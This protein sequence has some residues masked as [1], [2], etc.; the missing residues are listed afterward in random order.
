M[1]DPWISLPPKSDP[2]ADP[3]M[4]P[5]GAKRPLSPSGSSRPANTGEASIT[6]VSSRQPL[7]QYWSFRF[8]G[9]K[10]SKFEDLLE[11]FTQDWIVEYGFQLERGEKN[12]V[13][14]Y[15]GAFEVEPRKRFCQLDEYFRGLFPELIF[16]GK[17]YLQRSRSCAADRYAMKEETRVGGPWYFGRRFDEIAKETVYKI[18]IELRQ[19][20]MNI[21]ELIRGPNSDRYIYWFWEPFGGLGKTTF[22]K[23]LF[24][25][26]DRVVVLSGKASDMKNGIVEY[27]EKQKAYPKIVL[28]NIP[29]TFNAD[30][31]SAPGTEEIKD[32]FF[33]SPKFHGGMVWGPPPIVLIFANCVPPCFT[34]M[35]KDRWRIYRLPDGQ[36][37]DVAEVFEEDWSAEI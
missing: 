35:A 36:A 30:Y 8:T 26:F 19:W 5:R 23:W 20:Q 31:F 25:E 29:K 33:Y 7:V 10:I 11:A 28:I 37:K 14:H 9:S 16:D 4:S 6:G 13:L 24:Q 32:M 12:G 27:H 17:D 1:S 34:D 18:D 21:V 15:Q 2:V 3:A 22:Q